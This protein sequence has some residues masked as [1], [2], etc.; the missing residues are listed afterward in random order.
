MNCFTDHKWNAER[1]MGKKKN[2]K[3][4]KKLNK[5]TKEGGRRECEEVRKGRGEYHTER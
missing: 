3:T 1:I 5:S 2:K 4:K